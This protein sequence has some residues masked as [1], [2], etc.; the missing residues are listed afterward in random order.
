MRIQLTFSES[1]NPLDELSGGQ[2]ALTEII[3]GYEEF[4]DELD[5][6]L[7]AITQGRAPV[8]LKL[9]RARPRFDADET[10]PLLAFLRPPG[11]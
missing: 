9:D 11:A 4:L 5:A 10:Q 2:I 8:E 1:S 3:E 7:Q 6:R